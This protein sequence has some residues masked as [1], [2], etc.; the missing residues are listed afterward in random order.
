[1]ST[2]VIRAR[3]IEGWNSQVHKHEKQLIASSVPVG[4]LQTER[5]LSAYLWVWAE[6]QIQIR[7]SRIQEMKDIL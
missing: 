2:F 4:A 5:S 3:R 6:L 1:M 7:P